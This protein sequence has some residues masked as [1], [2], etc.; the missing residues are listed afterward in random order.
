MLTDYFYPHV[1]GGVEKV[2]LEVC[3]RL[4]SYGHNVC[5]LTLNTTN[6]PDEETLHGIR[7]VRVDAYDLTKITGLQS[8][9]SFNALKKGK[10]II[11]EFNPDI[12]HLHNIF[13][14]T[15]MIG[16]LLKKQSQAKL[17][18][19]LHLGAVDYL[20]GLKGLII[21]LI[22]KHVGGWILR[23][24]DLVTSVSNNV[25]EHGI[26]I[27]ADLRRCIVIP[28]GVDLDFFAVIKRNEMYGSRNVIFIGRLLFNKGPQILINSAKIVVKKLPDV[29]FLIVGEGPMRPE[30]ERMVIEN[31][32]SD[33][34]TFFGRLEDIRDIMAKANV[35]VRPSLLDGM[36]LGI[37]EAM[38]AG[39]PVIATNIAGTPEVI[40]HRKTGHLIKAGDAEDL[41]VAITEMLSNPGYATTLAKNGLELVKSKFDWNTVAKSYE[42]YYSHLMEGRS[43]F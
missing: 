24:S 4:V 9:I 7:I 12:I 42:T 14:F 5:V 39:L 23:H 26:K 35:Y 22:E 37:L 41:A 3:M 20:T 15:S 30:L 27:G 43:D 28:N 6:A 2:V 36:P 17:V 34:I 10:E 11:K 8:A 1:G 25:K 33:H 32:L 13:F 29:K 21:R 18:T 38:A 31:G 40:E 16:V 19:T